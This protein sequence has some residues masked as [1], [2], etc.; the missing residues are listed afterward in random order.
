MAKLLPVAHELEEDLGIEFPGTEDL[1]TARKQV[2]ARR[3]RRILRTQLRRERNFEAMLRKHK[4]DLAARARTDLHGRLIRQ[5][6]RHYGV[7]A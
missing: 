4:P 7:R 5:T 3:I 6:C 2:D 1:Y